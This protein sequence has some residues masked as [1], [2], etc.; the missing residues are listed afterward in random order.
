MADDGCGFVGEHGAVDDV[1]ESAAEK[2]DGLAVG[3]ARANATVEV[4]AS[5][6]GEAGLG[7]GDVMQRGVDLAVAGAA[8]AV[9][10]SVA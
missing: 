4:V 3:V 9:P 7:D 1:G 8:E 10:G 5:E 6:S 2:S